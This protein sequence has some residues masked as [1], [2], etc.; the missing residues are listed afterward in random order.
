MLLL[1]FLRCPH[2]VKRLWK[3]R[4]L[5]NYFKDSLREIFHTLLKNA[6]VTAAAW[7]DDSPSRLCHHCCQV[8]PASSQHP[9]PGCR[10]GIR[11]HLP[12]KLPPVTPEK[13][14]CRKEMASMLRNLNYGCHQYPAFPLM[15]NLWHWDSYLFTCS[16]RACSLHGLIF[17]GSLSDA[18]IIIGLSLFL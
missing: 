13:S 14:V 8:A 11:P 17:T 5:S 12:G 2:L 1:F 6:A 15:L 4:R 3:L 9:P 10:E 7:W 16:Y 18:F